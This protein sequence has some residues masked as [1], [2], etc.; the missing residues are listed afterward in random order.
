MIDK[1]D[2]QKC[3]GCK[4]CAD[5]CPKSAITFDV[6]KEGFW[7]PTVDYDKCVKCGL[8]VKKCIVYEPL[9]VETKRVAYAAYSKNDEI[10]R[11]S[12]SGGVYYELAQKVLKLGGYLVGSVYSEDYYSAHHIISNN[13]DDLPRIMGSKYFQS[14]TEEIYKKTKEILDQDNY[15]LFTGL[16]CQVHALKVF[17]N[18]DYEKLITLDLLCRGVPS[19]KMHMKKVQSYEK[20]ANCKVKSFRDKSKYEGWENFG[21]Y[22]TFQNGKTRFI[23]RWE[24]HINNCFIHLNLNIRESCYSCIFKD[25]NNAS[26]LTTGDF[27]GITGHTEKDAIYGVSCLISNTEK[28]DKFINSITDSLYLD[29]VDIESIS[30]G[31]PAYI[32]SAKRPTERDVFF[33]IT[34]KEGINAAVKYFTDLGVKYQIKNFIF[35]A[36]KEIKKHKFFI[37]NFFDI[38][39]MDFIILNYFSKN[40]V[41]NKEAHIYPMKGALLQ[42]DKNAKIELK[43][44]LYLNHYASYKKGN[45]QCLLK[46][47]NGGKLLVKDMVVLAYGN[48]LS[49]GDNAAFETGYLRTGVNANIICAHKMTFGQRV[50]LGRNVCIFDSDYHPIYNEA[51]DKIN[52]NKEVTIGDNCWVGANS[53]IL[54]GSKLENGCIVS[55][56]S[57]VMGNVEANKVYINKREAKSVGKNVVWK[58]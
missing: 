17:L 28:G 33:D 32:E 7:Y 4:M 50:M 36:K 23:S 8:C 13:P 56:N 57:M 24:D 19:P 34:E 39:L 15:V 30:K 51:F 6:D 14:D 16:P 11:E 43:G 49:V 53:M 21:E 38:K 44:N 58:I 42:I 18:K 35:K 26:D 12:T 37:K 31:N 40:V 5:I 29:R 48:T 25:G 10:R 54:K 3:T 52:E 20:K 41:R 46:I 45:S 2:Q 47:G 1:I 22:M 55:A 9:T 27:W